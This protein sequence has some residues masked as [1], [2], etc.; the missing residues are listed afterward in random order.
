[1]GRNQVKFADIAQNFPG[2]AKISLFKTWSLHRSS[3]AERRESGLCAGAVRRVLQALIAA[4]E[5]GRFLFAIA[6]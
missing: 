6:V 4:F 2:T 1:M 5:N 3:S